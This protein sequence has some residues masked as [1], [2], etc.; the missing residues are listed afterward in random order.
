MESRSA[1]G[2]SQQ[3][4]R[5]DDHEQATPPSSYIAIFCDMTARIGEFNALSSFGGLL[6]HRGEF[7]NVRKFCEKMFRQLPD[8]HPDRAVVYNNWGCYHLHKGKYDEA[9][10]SNHPDM[11]VAYR[12]IGDFYR[13][14]GQYEQAKKQ[15]ES[16]SK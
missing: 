13:S 6:L 16:A 7:E 5:S 14:I 4:D 2:R 1:L 9:L 8:N 11:I 15:Y 3:R 10:G 12:A